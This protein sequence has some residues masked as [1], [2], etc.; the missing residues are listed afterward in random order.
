MKLVK[1]EKGL[2]LIGLLSAFTFIT[3]QNFADIS[4]YS[5]F[6]YVINVETDF[7][8][9]PKDNYDDTEN[10]RNASNYA[11]TL[12]L[13]NSNAKIAVL[14]PP[15]N[16]LISPLDS[17][18]KVKTIPFYSG[19][20]YIGLGDNV[21]GTKPRLV[22][23]PSPCLKYQAVDEAT[24]AHC[25]KAN[26]WARMVNGVYLSPNPLVIKNITFYGNRNKQGPHYA[27]ELEQK[28]L[29]F[30]MGTT[31]QLK[32]DISDSDF[33]ESP[34]DGVQIYKNVDIHAKNIKGNFNYRGGM[35]ITGGKVN[36]EI[37][38]YFSWGDARP[39]MSF[40][41]EIDAQPT[42]G[43]T[44]ELLNQVNVKITNAKVNGTFDVSFAG[45]DTNF[46]GDNIIMY[47]GH[48]LYSG[49]NATTSLLKTT[50]LIKNSILRTLSGNSKGNTY[51]SGHI[52][53]P[54][55]LT[56]QNVQFYAEGKKD[57]E[58]TGMHI[59]FYN[60]YAFY[61]N[62]EVKFKNCRFK[63]YGEEAGLSSVIK[64]DP[65]RRG[66]NNKVIV[67]QAIIDAGFKYVFQAKKGGIIE[68][69]NI[70]SAA[71]EIVDVG[72]LKEYPL[73]I[74]IRNFIPRLPGQTVL[75]SITGMVNYGDYVSISSSSFKGKETIKQEATLKAKKTIHSDSKLSSV[76]YQSSML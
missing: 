61:D 8:A 69:N 21:N 66:S 28:S 68:A 60:S 45:D 3:F 17:K 62:Q 2:L 6:N 15:G 57:L 37:D 23:L 32:V 18:F 36:A 59:R 46:Y 11:K 1:Q 42:K 20:S 22:N 50:G 10:I 74:N 73:Q 29:L 16:Y 14:F 35:T 67:E 49:L 47:G 51:D 72:S 52:H 13:K 39:F 48:F 30:L 44:E 65:S 12:L 38:E 56:F 76:V 53:A 25:H 41:I 58:T 70:S 7:G 54:G 9:N 55:D 26:K 34:G 71:K 64:L 75:G 19:I 43:K 31:N 33:H 40:Q 63:I 24:F 5:D 4:D 27:Y